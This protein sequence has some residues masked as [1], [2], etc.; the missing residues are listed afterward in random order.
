MNEPIRGQSTGPMPYTGPS[1][2][3]A[4]QEEGGVV[5]RRPVQAVAVT[6][7]S[8]WLHLLIF[9][10]LVVAWW[11]PVKILFSQ[12][13]WPRAV[14][15]TP[16]DAYSFVALAYEGVSTKTNEVQ[17]S[18]F[19]DQLHALKDAGYMPI[20]LLDVEALVHEGKPVPRKAVL[21][22]FDHARRTSYFAV[23]SMLRQA[24]WNAVMFLWTRPIVEHDEA[25]LLW[26]YV[27][28]MVR[29]RIW[30]IG[31]ES[32]D[33]FSRIPCS[34]KGRLGNFMTSPRWIAGEKRFESLREFQERLEAD[35]T[36]C[37]Q[38]IREQ[39]ES[40]PI[41]YAYP[42]GDFGQY[43]SRA[44][45]TR[46][47]NLAL[48]EKNYRLGFICGNL[49]VN[50]RYSDARRLNR[51]LVRPT[52]SGR[53]LVRYLDKSWPVEGPQVQG[54]GGMKPAS[55]IVDWG[56]MEK[57]PDGSL[58]MYA[59][60]NT[61][62]AKMWLAGSDMNRDFYSRV[63]FRLDRGQLGLYLRASADGESYVYLGIDAG[64][65][66]WLRQMSHGK[67][68]LGGTEAA[69]EGGVWLRQ[70]QV[71]TERF[72]LA[73]SHVSIDSG[74]EHTLEVYLRDR[75]L[76]AHL[77]GKE[78][79][80]SRSLLRG[81][82][83]PGM[84]G[85]SVWSPG[86]GAARAHIAEVAL[87][88]QTPTLASWTTVP[89]QEPYVF[90]W[91]Y[92]NAFRLTHLSP[93]WMRATV[94]GQTTEPGFDFG[95]YKL[96]ARV[97][98][99]KFYPQ[100]SID[101]EGVLPR[102]APTLL[103]DRVAEIKADGVFVNL[104]NL[105]EP[106]VATLAAWIRQCGRA[107]QDKGLTF[108]LQMPE[109]LENRAAIQS[110]L[111][112]VPNV[113]VVVGPNAAGRKDSGLTNA[114]VVTRDD[115]PAPAADE[116]L[117][118]F[119]MIQGT[120][121]VTPANETAESK[122][123]RLQQEGLAA[124]LD[125]QFAKAVEFWKEWLTLEPDSSKALML[126]GDGLVRT[127]DLKGA[128]VYYDRSL[129]IDP[130]QVTLAIRRTGLYATLGWQDKAIASL[131]LYARLFPD[132]A[133]ILLAQADWL[134]DNGRAGEAK[135]VALKVLK[136]DPQNIAALT[137]VLRLC[138]PADE[139]Y[140]KSM[141]KL[142]DAGTKPERQLELG[143]ALWR[144]DIMSMPGSEP[145]ARLAKE[146]VA[147]T[148]DAR[149]VEIF[150]RI[151]P[152]Y[153]PAVDTFADGHASSRW[154]LEGGT[155]QGKA[156][157]VR[158]ATGE[159]YSEA[160][161]RLLG[162]LQ[163]R[164][165]FVEAVVGEA[166]GSFWLYTSRADDHI[167]R[168]GFTDDGY[169]YLQLRRGGRLLSERKIAWKHPGGRVRLRME[170]SADGVMGYVDGIPMFGSRLYMPEDIGLGWLGCSIFATARGKASATLY[171]LSAGPTPTRLAVLGPVQDAAAADA[172][173][174]LVRPDI[175][176]L[177]G[178]CPSWY[179]VQETGKWVENPGGDRQIYHVFARYHRVWLL[180]MVEVRPGAEVKPE[181]LE[182]KAAEAKA[183]GFLLIFKEWPADAWMTAT[184]ERLRASKLRV[185][186][187]VV[188][189]AGG[190]TQVRGLAR[191]LD[192]TAGNEDILKMKLMQKTD[193]AK[194]AGGLAGEGP[195]MIGY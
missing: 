124:F 11:Y 186:V 123:V 90:R 95:I 81:E 162:S 100:V 91:I 40:T 27:K 56:G 57:D 87:H 22:T 6:Y 68:N 119:Y 106:T 161:L 184:Q 4:D 143:Q 151:A 71:S 63:R 155:C 28:S 148:K 17:P 74:S 85:L 80:R 37:L 72:T 52:W 167:A 195:V 128:I 12:I 135:D 55:W 134:F 113:N 54:A 165:A 45:V 59:C 172:Q 97:N 16:H 166:H 8:A 78:L 191:G 139:L 163:M 70:K 20:T 173:L 50:T 101:D 99:L 24:G 79:F 189:A 18:Q 120:P 188:D 118:L 49:A 75:L 121:E 15:A 58:A 36:R 164:N 34:P 115:V 64:G 108:L 150:G 35:H 114:P 126:I 157:M 159:S 177:V 62:G 192:L 149:I 145:L 86:A 168:F 1:R 109:N 44:I 183:D 7:T 112:I 110:I 19:R 76:F 84:F 25:S 92:A 82:L 158:L 41:A 175:A 53:D 133:D 104:G 152:R 170:S 185:I 103:A 32:Y 26:P 30:E 156:G 125:G 5:V 60:T 132:N 77:D 169:M 3:E 69:E 136:V 93:A 14:A 141:K 160:A 127:G 10:C 171:G 66:V 181:D 67:D 102:I 13:V 38:T 130:G 146:I 94:S 33:G 46:P 88:Q 179:A 116:E 178:L 131:N 21:L 176:S 174:Q 111:A 147:K 129:D 190:I 83:K 138:T 180:P 105:R 29:S 194:L 47:V 153:D 61:T 140:G 23:H 48:V 154:W 65:E 187:G 73:S 137:M 9:L 142:A 39:A 31:A 122:V 42:F 193:L 98:H 107:L 43:Q 89:A 2:P 51:L 182:A 96:L 144:H 117:P